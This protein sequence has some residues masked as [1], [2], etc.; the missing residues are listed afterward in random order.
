MRIFTILICGFVV[1]KTIFG[2][3]G[4]KLFKM[5]FFFGKLMKI[6]KNSDFVVIE[7]DVRLN[8]IF[9]AC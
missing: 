9:N 5:F 3:F 1:M 2:F 4:V 7:I 8:L 6:L